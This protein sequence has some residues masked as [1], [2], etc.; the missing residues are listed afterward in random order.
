MSL[1]PIPRAGGRQIVGLGL[2][3]VFFTYV[4][5]YD[6]LRVPARFGMI[7]GALT[8]VLCGYA[9][10]AIGRWRRGGGPRPRRRR[11]GLPR[12]GVGR[13]GADQPDV[14]LDAPATSRRG[15]PCT[16]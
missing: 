7:A 5:G 16:A 3:D 8:A 13:A 9:L 15:R 10:A 1:G 2:Y 4:P 12:R 11:P 6:G 14:V